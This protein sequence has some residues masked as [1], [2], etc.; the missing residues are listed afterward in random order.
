M[1]KFA[2]TGIKTEPPAVS[3]GRYLVKLEKICLT[4]PDWAK[5]S[6]GRPRNVR[7]TVYKN[8]NP[9]YS[10]LLSGARGERRPKS[11][12]SFQADY[13]K[14]DSYQIQL[15]EEVVI[16]TATWSPPRG[17]KRIYPNKPINDYWPFNS[18][19]L[20]FT[21][22]SWLIFSSTKAR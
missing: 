13:A 17:I 21:D 22:N 20:P 10:E 14:D 15:E 16:V 3:E 5:D 19:K 12:C 2:I 7:M 9:V 1:I 18:R 6:S 8:G 11:P 4:E